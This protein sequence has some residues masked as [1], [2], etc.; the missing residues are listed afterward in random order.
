MNT[1]V[2]KYDAIEKLIYDE[3]LRIEAVDF[4]P[5]L[6]VMLIVLNTKAVLHQRISTYKL[7]LSA[8]K[9]ALL[10]YELTGNGTG[11]HWP[12]LDEDLSLKGFLQ[13]ELRNVVTSGKDMTIT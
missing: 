5:E 13:D 3:D 6:D 2:N 1:L 8:D 9:Q 11:V 10:Q 7:L 12:L 4:H